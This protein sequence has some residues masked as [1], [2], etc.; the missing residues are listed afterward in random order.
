MYSPRKHTPQTS[1]LESAPPWQTLATPMTALLLRSRL[2]PEPA[3]VTSS[4]PLLV[5]QSTVDT[6]PLPRLARW[7]QAL[8]SRLL[9][10]TEQSV[11]ESR[12]QMSWL[13][14]ATRTAPPHETRACYEFAGRWQVQTPVASS[15][16]STIVNSATRDPSTPQLAPVYRQTASRSR[17]GGTR[18][19]LSSVRP[20]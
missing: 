1:P 11:F 12:V 16:R 19:P 10:S 2:T 5:E 7:E 18:G 4:S 6:A 13:D 9:P 3:H 20:W 14:R 15:E 8:A 17:C